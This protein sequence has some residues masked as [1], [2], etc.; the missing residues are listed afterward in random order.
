MMSK[1]QLT[2]YSIRIL[3]MKLTTPNAL[4]TEQKE[5][6]RHGTP[7]RINVESTLPKMKLDTSFGNQGIA[8][9]AGPNN[10]YGR[11]SSVYR[12]SDDTVWAVTYQF[13][14]DQP[15]DNQ[16]SIIKLDIT[17]KIDT[18]FG[19][20]GYL[21]FSFGPTYASLPL[22]AIKLPHSSG[23]EPTAFV[24][25]GY[26]NRR[27]GLVYEWVLL[28]MLASGKPDPTFG[29]LGVV[30]VAS[31]FSL[32]ASRENN[33]WAYPGAD[34]RIYLV[35]HGER[36][37]GFHTYV[38]RLTHEGALDKDFHGTGY[39]ELLPFAGLN[40]IVKPEVGAHGK[41][42][43]FGG[44]TLVRF[45]AEWELDT[46]FGEGGFLKIEN[47]SFHTRSSLST[48]SG[49]F[50][51]LGDHRTN[52]TTSHPK[53]IKYTDEGLRDTR[54]NDGEPVILSIPD[55][56]VTAG[57]ALSA[58]QL[59]NGGTLVIGDLYESDTRAY[60]HFMA[61]L[62]P[63]GALDDRYEEGVGIGVTNQGLSPEADSILLV[64]ENQ[65]QCC[66]SDPTFQRAEIIALKV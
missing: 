32:N 65:L 27:P 24:V 35:V 61:H 12:D 63:E 22:Q 21:P 3:T 62:T 1:Q 33:V 48:V 54:F 46:G 23:G 25:S 34:N 44:N 31:Y 14:R 28:K 45:T 47:P 16:C 30:N 36:A 41:I 49:G 38:A 64:G 58:E 11:V 53:I 20:A 39:Y 19:E 7:Y 40:I 4:D 51:L 37:D 17:G 57:W 56:S 2:C 43:G 6:V 13:P 55:A 9:C 52:S 26:R 5:A 42:F 18:S 10:Q 8:N 66:G 15:T 59:P 29:D 50:L 60:E